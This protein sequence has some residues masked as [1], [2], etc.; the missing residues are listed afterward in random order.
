[1]EFECKT[2][3]ELNKTEI[4]QI[5]ER[6][7][8]SVRAMFTVLISVLTLAITVNHAYITLVAYAILYVWGRKIY[9]WREM[10]AR[11]A[12][13]AIVF[14]END[15]LDIHQESVNHYATMLNP[16]PKDDLNKN[17]DKEIN[18]FAITT[19]LLSIILTVSRKLSE[20]GVDE[21]FSGIV[22]ALKAINI[23]D[24]IF[25]LLSSVVMVV[26][27]VYFRNKDTVQKCRERW[28]NLY[29]RIKKDTKWREKLMDSLENKAAKAAN[30]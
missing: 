3:Y 11:H 29:M 13:Y 27:I 6:Y 14:L 28:I 21:S 23:F 25:I 2:E 15:K 9:M 18:F 7:E 12:A 19:W 17:N 16:N 22:E 4:L 8:T 1:M 30:K 10:V 5:I 20:Q 24:G 26:V